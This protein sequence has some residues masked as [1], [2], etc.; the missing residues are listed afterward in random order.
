[1]ATKSHTKT[2]KKGHKEEWSWEETP[3]VT[4]ALSKLHQT[5]EQNK[6]KLEELK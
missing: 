5:V 6:L 1:M 3:E 4:E 2:G